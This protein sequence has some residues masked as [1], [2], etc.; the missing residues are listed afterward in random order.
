M[1]YTLDERLCTNLAV[2][3]RREWLLTN[4]IGGF[5]M[6]TASGVAT[7]RYHGHLVAA[8]RPPTERMVLLAT[9]EAFLHLGG[10]PVGICANQYA[11][12]VYPDGH[13]LLKRFSVG[14]YATWV[15]QSG[16]ATVSKRLGLHPGRNAA[17]IRYTNESARPVVITLKPLVCHKPYHQ[18]FAENAEYPDETA[19]LP[20]AVQIEH[21]GV[22]LWLGHPA[23]QRSMVEGWYYRF[24]HVLE[25][26]RGLP[27]RDDLYCPVELAYE[28]APGHSAYLLA[29]ADGPVEPLEM[30]DEY[31][32][33]PFDPGRALAQSAR[34]FLVQG[35]R[36]TILA[37]YPWFTDWGRDTM[38]SLPG[39]CLSTGRI[40][41]ARR[42]LSDFASSMRNG[43][44]PNRFE[45]GGGTDYHTADATLWFAHA[46]GKTLEREWDSEFATRMLEA[47]D[48]MRRHH[49]EGT[50]FGIRID[51]VDGLLTQG[52]EGLQMTWMDAKIGDWVV[53]PRTGKTIELNALWIQA[54]R[55]GARICER[56]DQRDP[57][58]AAA[59]DK[60]Q[61]SLEPAFWSE[62]L[63]YYRD[64]LGDEGELLR[65]NQAIA[66]SLPEVQFDPA[67][68][69]KALEAIGRELFTPVGLRTLSPRHPQYKGAFKGHIVDLDSAYHQGTVWPWLLGPYCTAY[70]RF[71]GSPVEVRKLF[72][73]VKV[74]M[75]E[76]GLGGIAE[77]YDGDVPRSAGGCPWQAWSH[78]ELLRVWTDDLGHSL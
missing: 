71:G 50:D 14:R 4:G 10:H 64:T 69:R 7:R 6:G 20:D 13:E 19:F 59:A 35:P 25:S 28:L 36:T 60:A 21:G 49:L 39:L 57:G 55:V 34:Y 30:D 16:K 22:S 24:E 61:E 45:D 73:E 23:A 63:G 17:T 48:Q 3:A 68:A 51:P 33:G 27:S 2:S 76:Y 56:L 31:A 18:N 9:V 54:M 15:Y 26:E 52:G 74:M 66:L 11:G 67:H 77:V 46:V 70:L 37:G 29:S 62:E 40:A 75:M 8:V 1:L 44:I 12:A 32:P 65:P 53:T 5:A 47:L 42:I 78:A 38:I 43:L 58:F 41:T 72:R